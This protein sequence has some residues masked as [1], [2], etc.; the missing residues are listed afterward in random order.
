MVSLADKLCRLNTGPSVTG[1]SMLG[2]LA[3]IRFCPH[4]HPSHT[5]PGSE[6]RGGD[7]PTWDPALSL[8][9]QIKATYWSNN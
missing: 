1:L 7:I 2:S 4:R 5:V 9:G 3:G 8:P 6:R